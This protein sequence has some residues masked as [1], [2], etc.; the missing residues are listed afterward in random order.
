MSITPAFHLKLVLKNCNELNNI[1][2]DFFKAIT[3]ELNPQTE[4]YNF[5]GRVNNGSK[6]NLTISNESKT[7]LNCLNI[8]SIKYKYCISTTKIS[9]K[10]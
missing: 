6:R 10:T 1:L 5:D 2:L 3:L 7:P 4:L 9:D 8:Y